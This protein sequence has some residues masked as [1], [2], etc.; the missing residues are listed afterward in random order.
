ME[1]TP[2]DISFN[3]TELIPKAQI[4]GVVPMAFE[5]R[6]VGNTDWTY[7]YDTITRVTIYLRNGRKLECELQSITNQA[8]WNGGTLSDL[9]QAIAD[10]NPWLQTSFIPPPPPYLIAAT[11]T[12]LLNTISG[13]TYV[14]GVPPSSE[15]SYFKILADGLIP[16]S[17]TITV[18]PSTNIEIFWQGTWQSAPFSFAYPTPNVYFNFSQTV[19]TQYIPLI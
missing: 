16:T 2:E 13:L 17:G 8:T 10:I 7:P 19:N 6:Q 9:Q 14:Y 11:S 1:I 3:A 5:Q 15:S 12:S 4:A 18:T